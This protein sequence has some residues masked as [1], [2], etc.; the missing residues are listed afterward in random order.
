M[1]RLF[2]LVLSIAGLGLLG[3]GGSANVGSSAETEQLAQELSLAKARLK[4]LERKQ[5]SLQADLFPIYQL[6]PHA[7]KA[8]ATVQAAAK[9]VQAMM[10]SLTSAKG[11]IKT[12]QEDIK[13]SQ[14]DIEALKKQLAE[15]AKISETELKKLAEKA[16]SLEKQDLAI[17]SLMKTVEDSAR[18]ERATTEPKKEEA[19]KPAED[20]GETAPA[21]ASFLALLKSVEV[22]ATA[23]RRRLDQKDEALE[24]KDV[25]LQSMLE[26][27][28]AVAR[29]ERLKLTEAD[30]KLVATDKLL[31]AKDNALSEADILLSKRDTEIENKLGTVEESAKDARDRFVKESNRQDVAML[32]M[33]QGIEKTLIAER[34]KLAGADSGVPV[35]ADEPDAP[36]DDANKEEKPATAPSFEELLETVKKT[37]TKERLDSERAY[38]ELVKQDAKLKASLEE[39]AKTAKEERGKLD[40]RVQKL[41]EQDVA[42]LN[43]VK[44]FAAGEAAKK[45]DAN[46]TDDKDSN[47]TSSRD[48]SNSFGVETV[49]SVLRRFQG[50][51][52][53]MTVGIDDDE[54][55][56]GKTS[57]EDAKSTAPGL[58]V[59]MPRPDKAESKSSAKKD[60]GEDARPTISFEEL[61]STVKKT[62]QSQREAQQE[63]GAKLDEVIKTLEDKDQGLIKQLA[64]IEKRLKVLEQIKVI[65]NELSAEQDRTT[66]LVSRVKVLETVGKLL[67]DD[68]SKLADIENNKKDPPV[69]AAGEILTRKL[70]IVDSNSKPIL[71]LDGRGPKIEFHPANAQKRVKFAPGPYA[72]SLTLESDN[73]RYL[74]LSK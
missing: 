22:A 73:G 41:A 29:A 54:T 11:E 13:A 33:F 46:K 69:I 20:N 2:L 64:D 60:A 55:E 6:K 72:G 45:D 28:D 30:R 74:F 15:H 57:D 10:E 26:T 36:A 51:S 59:P 58:K 17:L 21:T 9:E 63:S 47:E 67:R 39:L 8:V 14:A 1:R 4:S 38:D 50:L 27:V 19:D 43:L 5:A 56:L 68:V 31:V 42:I 35:F 3:C 16:S 12:A 70:T 48:R 71:S 25:E 18:Q 44:S 52:G 61:L 23:E 65:K 62:A 66:D 37:T 32:A 7:D 40:A 53:T 24:R 49:K 34:Q